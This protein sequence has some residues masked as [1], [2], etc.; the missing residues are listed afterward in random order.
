MSLFKKAESSVAYLKAGIFG[1]P[2]SGK[3]TTSSMIAIGLAKYLASKGLP[4][5]PVMMIDTE[6]G[7][8]WVKDL[9]DEA[10]V[11]FHVAQTRKFEQLIPMMKEAEAAKAI[12]IGDSVTHFWKDLNASALE[13]K[14]E[15]LKRKKVPNAQSAKL[16][17]P[18]FN[19]I[20]SRWEEFTSYYLRSECHIIICGRAASVFDFQ[21]NEESGKK[22]LITIGTRMAAEKHL[23]YECHLL[24]EM[25]AEQ[26]GTGKKRG[27]GFTHKAFVMKDRSRAL[28]G[29]TVSNPTFKTFL[30]HIQKMAIGGQHTAFKEESSVGMFPADESDD[31]SMQRKIVLDEIGTLLSRKYPST[32]GADKKAKLDL[33]KDHFNAAWTEMEKLMPLEALRTGYNNLHLALEGKPSKYGLSLVEMRQTPVEEDA[34]PE[35]EAA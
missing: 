31:R 35:F 4:Q 17:M 30:P 28:M 2:G 19:E 21:E 13:A 18:D 11:E 3:T 24:L 6:T 10:G 15:R 14:R 33:L 27:S 34:L 22:E 5:P 26:N 25:F 20:K 7:N 12:L 29:Q 9:Y 8:S 32:G 23:G 1:D 16:E